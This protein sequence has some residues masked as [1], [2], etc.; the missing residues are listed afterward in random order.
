MVRQ[1]REI[2]KV[3]QWRRPE[4][5]VA[6]EADRDTD[7]GRVGVDGREDDGILDMAEVG[8]QALADAVRERRRSAGRFPCVAVEYVDDAADQ[9]LIFEIRVDNREVHRLPVL[10]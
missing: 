6:T 10:A 7:D 2:V 5:R 4:A 9:R 8:D 1:D 3:E